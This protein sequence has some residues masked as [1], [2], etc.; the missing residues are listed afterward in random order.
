MRLQLRQSAPLVGSFSF[1]DWIRPD[2]RILLKCARVI[3]H[4][5]EDRRIIIDHVF[6]LGRHCIKLEGASKRT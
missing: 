2:G 5:T 4:L 3:S 1:E 6:Y